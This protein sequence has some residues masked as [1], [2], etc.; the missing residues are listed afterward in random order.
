[1]D[2]AFAHD[3][4]ILQAREILRGKYLV[5]DTET[6][7]LDAPE[8]C[9]LAYV[10]NDGIEFNVFVKPTVPI[11]PT[12]TAIHGITN[13]QVADA[14]T[15]D[16]YWFAIGPHMLGRTLIGY[17]LQYDLG[18]LQ[19]SFRRH[20]ID[21]EHRDR[22]KFDVMYAYA[23]YHGEIHSSQGTFKW[24]KLADALQQCGLTVEG[25][26]HDALVDAKAT[27]QLVRYMADQY[28]TWEVA[29]RT[30]CDIIDF[31]P[32]FNEQVAKVTYRKL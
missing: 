30:A 21:F 20:N 26:V 24:Q 14:N 9:Q 1:M 11:L 10:T 7:G 2:K 17:N 16:M 22:D 23:A 13:E 8:A 5:L 27:L 12:A 15:I 32:S 3:E 19:T 29:L 31:E 6:T 28:T 4:A 25:Q 18:A